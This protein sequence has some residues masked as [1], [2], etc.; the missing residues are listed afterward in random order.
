[1]ITESQV[2]VGYTTYIKLLGKLA[3]GKEIIASGMTQE[4]Y[5]ASLAVKKAIEGK[6][7]CI[8]SSGDP[9]I[10]GMAGVVLELVKKNDFDKL[11]I[12]IIPGITAACASASLLGAPLTQDF[13]VIS[14]S[15]LMVK[16]TQIEKRLRAAAKADF[17]I[18]LYNPKSKSR[19]K[20]LLKAWSI[21]KKY[22]VSKTPVGIVRN[23]YRNNV[24]VDI[25]TLKEA[26]IRKDIDMATTI[27]VGNSNTFVKNKYMITPRGYNIEGMRRG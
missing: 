4:L 22:R 1:M 26:S 13:A 14:L 19:I 25:T 8:I 2:I 11:Q 17:S 10:Y 20:P 3:R 12:E 6:N 16:R 21:I 15:D 27:I 24:K 5:R 7:V 23:A 9:G 18:V